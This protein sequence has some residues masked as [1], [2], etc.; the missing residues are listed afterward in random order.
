[1]YILLPLKTTLENDAIYQNM[2]KAGDHL[3]L[4]GGGNQK[5]TSDQR[6]FSRYNIL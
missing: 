6:W 2:I 4:F 1:M 3:T 5:T